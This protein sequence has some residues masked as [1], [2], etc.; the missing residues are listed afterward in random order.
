MT[1][2]HYDDKIC[3]DD[4]IYDEKQKSIFIF[5]TFTSTGSKRVLVEDKANFHYG[6]NSPGD[7]PDRL[8][9][10]RVE[11]LKKLRGKTINFRMFANSKAEQ[12]TP[13]TEKAMMDRVGNHMTKI[14]EIISDDDRIIERKKEELMR[15][16]DFRKKL[17]K[18]ISG[19]N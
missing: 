6:S 18:E 5:V 9:Y 16:E 3:I 11:L 14:N 7:F 13:E 2:T 19:E 12:Y 15:V 17:K 10:Q 8:M 1:E 4:A